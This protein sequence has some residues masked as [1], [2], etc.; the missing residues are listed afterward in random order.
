MLHYNKLKH[1]LKHDRKNTT[2][3]HQA[4]I[5]L[6]KTLKRK[7]LQRRKTSLLGTLKQQTADDINDPDIRYVL[8]TCC[9]LVLTAFLYTAVHDLKAIFGRCQLYTYHFHVEFKAT[10]LDL[11]VYW[12]SF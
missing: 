9:M 3:L 10:P 12:H 2:N 1:V 7:L 8:I 4:A 11:T 5:T 6:H